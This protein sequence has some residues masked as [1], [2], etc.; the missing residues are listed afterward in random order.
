M[1]KGPCIRD[2]GELSQ[3]SCQSTLFHGKCKTPRT[4]KS[5]R[6]CPNFPSPSGVI[7]S[8]IYLTCKEL[9]PQNKGVI[10]C[11]PSPEKQM[12][13]MGEERVGLRVECQ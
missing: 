9:G 1:G 5:R 12:L 11:C 4:Q 10:S 3:K 7:K 13:K 8:E 6:T 2:G